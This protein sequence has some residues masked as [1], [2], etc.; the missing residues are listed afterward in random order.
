MSA[1]KPGESDFRW[2][3]PG[4][5]WSLWDIMRDFSAHELRHALQSLAQIVGFSENEGEKQDWGLEISE[6]LRSDGPRLMTKM[7]KAVETL[8]IPITKFAIAEIIEAFERPGTT[9]DEIKRRSAEINNTLRRELVGIQFYVPD[10]RFARLLDKNEK[11]FDD[12]IFE[13]FSEA[14][15]D[16]EEA[17]KCL[18]FSR[19]A[20]GVFHMMRAAESAM[21]KL[22]SRLQVEKIDFKDEPRTWGKLLEVT[23]KKIEKL[24][25]GALKSKYRKA[26]LALASLNHIYRVDVSHGNSG[27][28]PKRTYTAEQAEECF[29]AT[30]G[31]MRQVAEVLAQKKATVR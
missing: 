16:M 28:R 17:G 21:F 26:H 12:A 18:A 13:A 11:L 6:S 20:A 23:D 29:H 8:P 1:Y 3:Q 2:P 14:V 5:L 19:Y 27:L 4:E 30:A 22:A 25:S 15:E 24:K 9:Y 10:S 7:L 31:A